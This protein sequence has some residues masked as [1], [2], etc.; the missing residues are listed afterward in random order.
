M[1]WG[2]VKNWLLDLQIVNVSL[3]ILSRPRIE[4]LPNILETIGTNYDQ[5]VLPSI[6]NEV[7]I[8]FLFHKF[9]NDVVL[10]LLLGFEM[11]CGTIQRFATDN[12]ETTGI[13]DLCL[14]SCEQHESMLI[15][16]RSVR[17]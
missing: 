9:V 15:L 16:C 5:K 10:L 2:D 12:H 13:V 17:W 1:W 3:R 14:F 7:D 4:A 6:G 11:C 8:D